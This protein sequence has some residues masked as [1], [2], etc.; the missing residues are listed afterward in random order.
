MIKQKE[1]WH[2]D[3]FYFSSWRDMKDV[4]MVDDEPLAHK[5]IGVICLVG[6]FLILFFL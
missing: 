6:C 4:K 3:N 1:V 2:Q 5:I